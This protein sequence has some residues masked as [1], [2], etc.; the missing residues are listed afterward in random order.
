MYEAFTDA[1]SAA[2]YD[3]LEIPAQHYFKRDSKAIC[4]ITFSPNGYLFATGSKDGTAMLWTMKKEYF[5]TVVLSRN[6]IADACAMAFSPDSQQWV[7]SGSDGNAVLGSI[8]GE[9]SHQPDVTLKHPAAVCNAAFSPNGARILTTSLDGITRIWE[10]G[11]TQ[12]AVELPPEKNCSTDS[13]PLLTGLGVESEKPECKNATV[14][15]FGPDGNTVV[16]ASCET[17]RVWNLAKPG[18]STL[19]GK[20]TAHVRNVSFSRDGST[21][22][23]I[24]DD[25]V[26]LW[27]VSATDGQRQ[28]HEIP[29]GRNASFNP[30]GTRLAVGD[31]RGLVRVYEYPGMKQISQ[32]GAVGTGVKTLQFTPDG[33]YL[34]VNSNSGPAWMQKVVGAK[35]LGVVPEPDK[36]GHKGFPIKFAI[37]NGTIPS[38][39]NTLRTEVV[40]LS[41]DA[42]YVVAGYEDG[43][44]ALHPGVNLPEDRAFRVDNQI[45]LADLKFDKSPTSITAMWLLE[46]LH[47]AVGQMSVSEP[48]DGSQRPN[49]ADLVS[50]GRG[51]PVTRERIFSTLRTAIQ[52]AKNTA[53]SQRATILVVYV[54]AHGW[55]GPDGRKYLL[56]SDADAS[57]PGTWIAYDDLLAP[58]ATYLTLP[59]SSGARAFNPKRGAIVIFDTCQTPLESAQKTPVV[60]SAENLDNLTVIESTSPGEPAW[61][62]TGNVHATDY[63]TSNKSTTR[64]G[65]TDNKQPKHTE[66]KSD[67]STRMSMFPYASQW[68]LYTLIKNKGTKTSA[69][70]RVITLG[71]WMSYTQ[72]ALQRLLSDMPDVRESGHVQE[73]RYPFSRYANFSIFEVEPNASPE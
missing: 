6:H 16:T 54:A 28:S 51:E 23:S 47:G 68:A 70:D 24:N 11:K 3:T 5:G 69:E 59:S 49:D 55:I 9:H 12:A 8:Y 20:E 64:F 71:E 65:I 48:K 72:E 21:V 29:G 17:V 38:G 33:Q 41:P 32:L 67:Y 18:E 57:N 73:V 36:A 53:P 14:A 40:A 58:I 2:E 46:Q 61:H 60:T 50:L 43:S 13:N 44:I 27:P 52:K 62:W 19:L 22:L 45:L 1:A 31:A 25:G 26:M 39:R 15:A 63:T 66:T 4:A 10:P 34:V 30:D 7:T 42:Q 35:R 37:D 56:P